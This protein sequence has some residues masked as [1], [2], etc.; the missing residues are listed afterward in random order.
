MNTGPPARDPVIH[1]FPTAEEEASHNAWMEKAVEDSLACPE[2]MA[3]HGQV[4]AEI[5]QFLA[6]MLKKAQ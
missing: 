5:R 6:G 4:V 2:P 3:D 1:A